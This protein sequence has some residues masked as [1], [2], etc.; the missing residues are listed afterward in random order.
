MLQV[1]GMNDNHCGGPGLPKGR[2]SGLMGSFSAAS[3]EKS[4]WLLLLATTLMD[5]S[6][7]QQGK[8]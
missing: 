5:S 3:V 6:S 1:W 7:T 8:I 4:T 2:I